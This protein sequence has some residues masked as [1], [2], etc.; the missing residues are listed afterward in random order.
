MGVFWDKSNKPHS[1]L[2]SPRHTLSSALP[3]RYA[4]PGALL[5]FA[6][7]IAVWDYF[8]DVRHSESQLEQDAVRSLRLEAASLQQNMDYLFSK[9]ALA[10]VQQELAEKRADSEIEVALLG[11]EGNRIIAAAN[12]SVIGR[13]LH[14]RLA[15]LS[16]Q[17]HGIEVSNLL[18]N[19]RTRRV[20]QVLLSPDRDLV[21]SVQPIVLGMAPGQLRAGRVGTLILGRSLVTRK[22]IAQQ[23]IA[24]QVIG[25]VVPVAAF[26]GLLFVLSHFVITRRVTAIVQA[27]QRF[28]A[29]D[30]GAR[31][32]LRG[33]D[34]LAE[35]GAAFDGMAERVSS[36]QQVLAESE[37]RF[38]LVA[39]SAP[40]MIWMSG[41]DNLR[42]YFNKA[43]LDFTGRTLEQEQGEGWAEHIHPDDRTE[44][45]AI[46]GRSC[47][48]RQSFVMDYRLRPSDGEHRWVEDHGVPRYDE[49]GSFAGYIG[50]CVDVTERK[51]A[52]ALQ[53]C[54][55]ELATKLSAALQPVDAARTIFAAADH[56]WA[57]DTGVLDTYSAV[58][59]TTQTVLG[60]DI[61]EGKRREVSS[62]QL[63]GKPSPRSRRI[64]EQGS[65][66]ILRQ[67]PYQ[68]LSDSIPFGDTSRLSA[69]IMSVPVRWQGQSVGILSI[70]SYTPG[71]FSEEDL[72]VLQVLADECGGALHRLANAEAL[73]VSEERFRELAATIDEV[74][75]VS[76][77][78]KNQILYVS[79]AYERIW[80]RSCQS[81]YE[82]PRSW[83]D[84]IHADDREHIMQ[85][86]TTKQVAGT[87][88]EEYRIV[89][90]DRTVRWI[91]DRAFPVRGEG[92][93]V[94]R[95][96]GVAWEISDRKQFEQDL[97]ES[98]QRYRVLVE[99][100]PHC[101]VVVSNGRIVLI[102][103]Y[104]TEFLGASRPE[105][106]VGRSAFDFVHPDFRSAAQRRIQ[107]ALERGK[108]MPLTEGKYLRLDGSVVEVE[109]ASAPLTYY[110]QPA[111]QVVFQDISERKKAETRL[112]AAEK[113]AATG[114]MAAGIAHEINNPLAGI[115]TAFE[116]VKAAIPTDHA[117]MRFARMIDREINRISRIVTQM[118]TLYKPEGEKPQR[119]FLHEI[120]ADATELSLLSAKQ[121]GVEIIIQQSE[122][123]IECHVPVG[124]L[125]QVMLNLVGNALD[126]SPSGSVVRLGARLEE[127]WIMITVADRGHGIPEELRQRIFEPFYTT[128]SQMA[129]SGLGLGL[130]VS[131]SLIDAM[132]GR[133]TFET[134]P[135]S[136][137]TFFITIP[138]FVLSPAPNVE[139]RNSLQN[140]LAL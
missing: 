52:E 7:T 38:H 20:G 90:P 103:Q 120:I 81:L 85:V 6:A 15:E 1:L 96:V 10:Q 25:F 12:R 115:R 11:D 117:D 31:A 126:A 128:K 28:A 94:E 127:D 34:E 61:V 76:D 5:L 82:K 22:A 98:E 51:R 101:I 87:Y 8:H 53:K 124:S 35:V 29:G 23:R 136:G 139:T 13:M 135:G 122:T 134:E 71:A 48:A 84:A 3:L 102:N 16:I 9:D 63:P 59:D 46:Y 75:W 74:F 116:I 88:N 60:L 109:I 108:P 41:T 26:A 21:I 18:M 43:W 47:D 17:V 133:L 64:L 121:K 50:S 40:V 14:Q 138:Q 54:L 56:L 55:L 137:T 39:D 93:G 132:G 27:A 123:P 45:L 32:K 72:I 91:R 99:L 67:P 131:R 129:G 57:W 130:A 83:L 110:G 66:L 58:E 111:L 4:V 80:G 49:G 69:S 89:R 118:F 95:I 62:D 112:R 104:G 86:A 78:A 92:C 119:I 125:S 42:T 97:L 30:K 106:I 140:H 36:A 79:P 107:Q 33:R 113:H 105:E 73:R 2:V 114:R 77:P 19:V 37:A 24:R 70:Q 100:S 44:C 65:E 68:Q